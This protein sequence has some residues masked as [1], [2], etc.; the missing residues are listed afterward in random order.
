[1]EIGH[2]RSPRWFDFGAAA[3]TISELWRVGRCFDQWATLAWTDIAVKYRRT[4]LGPAWITLGL[5]V[6]VTSVGV[7]YGV[8]FGKDLS[9]YLPYFAIGIIAW[10]FFSSCVTEGC[11]VFVANGAMIK[12]I[13]VSM[14]VYVYRM[15]SRQLILLMHN[16]TLVIILWLI[17]R[18]HL[19]WSIVLLPAGLALNVLTAFGLI[20]MLGVVGARFRDVQL[21]VSTVLQLAFLLTPVMWQPNTLDGT[22]LRIFV[23]ANPLHALIEVLRQPAVGAAPDALTW[24]FALGNALLALALGV[25]FYARYRHRIAFW[26]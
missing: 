3:A 17:F 2:M 16:L 12:S 19:N 24:L 25:F 9:D 7:L 23:D 1:M 11:G 15:M 26:V 4:T 8:L 6:S 13:P 10:T 22:K 21:I 5:A 20:L 18:W 14:A